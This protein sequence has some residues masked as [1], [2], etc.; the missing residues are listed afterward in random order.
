MRKY[1]VLALLFVLFALVFLPGYDIGSAAEPPSTPRAD[2][3]PGELLI[4]FESGVSAQSATQ[5]LSTYGAARVRALY[6]SE[7]ELWRVP[8]GEELALAETLS[9]L[10]NVAYA[11]PNY[12]VHALETEPND[13]YYQNNDQWAHNI[14]HSALGWDITTGTDDVIIAIIDSG[15]DTTHPDLNVGNKFVPGYDYI[16]NDNTPNDAHGHGTHVAGVAAAATNNGIGVAGTSWGARIMPL[17]VLDAEGSGN[18]AAVI[19]AIDWAVDHGAHVINLSLGGI[20]GNTALHNA[21]IDARDNNV[22]VIAAAGNCGASNY[23]ANG[24]EEQDQPV[25]P[26]AYTESFAVAATNSGDTTGDFSNRGEYVDIAAPGVNIWSTYPDSQLAQMSGTSQATPYVAGLAALILSLDPTLTPDQVEAIIEQN[27]IDRGPSGK[28]IDYGHGRIDIG[29]T[30][31]SFNLPATPT[32]YP[33]E[34]ADEDGDYM[35]DWNTITDAVTYTLQVDD[36]ANFSTPQIAYIGGNTQYNVTGQPAGIW[37]YRVRATNTYGDSTW[38]DTRSVCVDCEKV[39]LPLVARNHAP[40]RALQNG[41]FES[42]ATGWL[43]YSTYG[44]DLIINSG[45]P[46]SVMPHGGQWAVWLGGAN[47][48]TSYIEQAVTIESQTPYL[49]YWHWIASEDVCGYDYGYV[50]VNG[51]V[52]DQYALCESESTG[53]WVQHSANLSTYTGQT[54]ILKIQ[55]VND[56]SMNSNL[57]IDDV[58]FSSSTAASV[59]QQSSAQID[60]DAAELK[61]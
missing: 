37:F 4:R 36:R 13:P 55:S 41:D 18:D 19:E 33:I 6:K 10:P 47:D 50:I 11:E 39:Y 57:L 54:V 20:R 26:A 46:G 52:V 8:A 49:T 48:E 3:A 61:P 44:F 21:I 30:L 9:A 16:D 29:A 31:A 22:V 28:D 51:V 15:V 42:G 25:Y 40:V 27:A 35:V 45:F 53:G 32:L 43:E 24:C 17:R 59:Q 12:L 14:M 1:R 5:A 23:E 60:A 2:F 34:N 38:G 56:S 7:V 58:A